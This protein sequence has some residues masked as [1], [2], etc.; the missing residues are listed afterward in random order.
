VSNHSG[1]LNE[2]CQWH[3]EWG[4]AL[5]QMAVEDTPENRQVIQ[6]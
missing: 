2:D 3:G 6:G 1:T 4:Q 5:V